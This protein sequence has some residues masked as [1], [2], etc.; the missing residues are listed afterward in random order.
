ME[1]TIADV[2]WPKTLFDDTEPRQPGLHL[3]EVIKSL[4][5]NSGRGYNGRGFTDLEL[6][7][8][9]GL[10]WEDVLSKVM[11]D[12]YA[13]RPPQIQKDGI[14]MSADG[15]GEDPIGEECFVVE[16]YKAA[17][18][19]SRKSPADN[20]YYMTQAK[21]YCYAWETPVVVFRI[22]YIVGDYRGSGPVYRV[23]RIRF[24]EYELAENWI[25]ILEEKK[26]MGR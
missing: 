22:F 1:Y 8:E 15:I 13:V 7:A 14:W 10:L 20:L 21:S 4:L 3:G 11:R 2:K 19:S 25:Q 9:I 18:G 23:A 17:W 12:K 24:T 6:T 5:N 16:E 26:R